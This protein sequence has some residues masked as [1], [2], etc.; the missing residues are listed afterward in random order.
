MRLARVGAP[1][2]ER[3]VVFDGAASYDLRPLTHDIDGEFLAADGVERIRQAM[4]NP[5]FVRRIL[6]EKERAYCRTPQQVAGRWA[7]KEAAAK[8]MPGLNRWH[9]VEV[10]NDEIGK[11]MLIVRM[12][13]LAGLRWHLSISHEKG[14]AAA[15]VVLEQED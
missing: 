7:A 3:P 6:T 4:E 2:A 8:C 9:M 13:G 10:V 11:P 5:R 12:S 15:M 14:V 1:G